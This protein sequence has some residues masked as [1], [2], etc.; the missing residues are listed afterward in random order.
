MKK[1]NELRAIKFTPSCMKYAEGSVLVEFGETKVI[2]TASFEDKVPPFLKNTGTGWVSAEYSML[3]RSTQI[4]KTRD[5][6]RGKIDG[7]THEIQR[8]IGRSL[9]SIIDLKALGEKTIWIDCDVL[10][11]DGGTRT[12]AITGAYIA[13]ALACHK[14]KKE[15]LIKRFPL[16]DMVSAVSVGIVEKELILDLCF[17]ED[18]KAHVDM[19]VVMTGKGQF[20]EIQSTGEEKPFDL[21]QFNQLLA[22]AQEGCQAITQAQ[23]EVLGEEILAQIY[24]RQTLVVKEKI[25]YDNSPYLDEQGRLE[26]VIASSN[27]HKIRE[28]QE[29]LAKHNIKLLSLADLGI[30][31]LEIE[32]NGATFEENAMIKAKAVMELTGK[33]AIAD[34]SGL[35]VDALDGAPGVYSAR[36]AG[37]ECD[38]YKNNKLLKQNLMSIPFEDRT[39]RFISVIALAF[40]DGREGFYKGVCEGTI[41]FNEI[42]DN[43][44][45]YDPL[46]IPLGSE[47]TFAQLTSEE[48]N[49]VSH[50]ARALK[51][52][53][54]KLSE[55]IGER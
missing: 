25:E 10:Q 18:S 28:I 48:K 45:G 54:K 36:Y 46:F 17:E 20:V 49:K 44:F 30:F 23:R 24:P 26:F 8:L 38:D 15:K 35:A 11:A 37:E 27:E 53:S 52:M 13:L 55:I 2:C 42:G 5:S 47:K 34:D 22:L 32:E 51:V 40:P 21:E 33:I 29:I 3:P 9:R 39:A 4:R 6:V 1:N 50:R 16:F 12:A 41:G 7:R 19:N 14:L 43:G 31:G